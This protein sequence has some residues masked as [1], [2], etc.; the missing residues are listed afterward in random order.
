MQPGTRW[1]GGKYRDLGDNIKYQENYN[2]HDFDDGDSVTIPPPALTFTLTPR[3]AI[4]A[5][6]LL[7]SSTL[8][9]KT[10]KFN[11]RGS[12]PTRLPPFS[13]RRTILLTPL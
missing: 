2:D 9:E 3:Q 6:R 13:A 11:T 8:I 4:F 7:Q 5:W 1:R 12:A 10:R